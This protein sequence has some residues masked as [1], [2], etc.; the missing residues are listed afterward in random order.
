MQTRRDFVKETAAALAATAACAIPALAADARKKMRAGRPLRGLVVWYS[1]TGNTERHGR[2]V[3]NVWEKKGLTVTAGDY[4][5]VGQVKPGAFDILM[6]GSPVYYYEVPENFRTWLRSIPV[7]DG[8]PV[9]A[10]VTC[11][12]EGG[13]QYNTACTL[14]EIMSERGGVPAGMITLN[15][16]STYAVTWSMGN[17]ERILKYRHL[18]D[19]ATFER[20]RV[21]AAG[22]LD[23]AERG[24]A[25][26]V[27]R[28]RNMQD[29]FSGG[30]SI[31]LCKLLTGN[32]HINQK[33]CIGCGA[34]E[35][36]CPVKAVN[37]AAGTV[38][39]DRCIACLGC[40][41][42]CPTGAMT[43]DFM[44]KRVRGWKLFSRDEK[45]MIREPKEL[46]GR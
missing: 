23:R 16:M 44:G 24:E 40:V 39:T 25:S 4:R 9:A 17:R 29:L 42:N 7:M 13:N 12:G 21:F 31:K 30:P 19:E 45:I 3:A 37:L 6:A 22:V 14:L 38:N 34:C 35:K 36:A 43:M 18:P 32:H 20:V 1:Q 10:F 2:L 11:G 27:V 8:T 46:A 28:K 33:E 26:D 15:N 41:N 5:D